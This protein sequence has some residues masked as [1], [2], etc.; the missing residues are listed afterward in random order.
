[1]KKLRERRREVPESRTFS[2]SHHFLC[3][4]CYF[5]GPLAI[6]PKLVAGGVIGN[7][8]TF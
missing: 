3:R 2:L 5:L 7:M 6:L 1:M 8:W 4:A